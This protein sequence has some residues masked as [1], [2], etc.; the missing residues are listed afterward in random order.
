MAEKYLHTGRY[1]VHYTVSGNGD[2][3]VLVHGFGEDSRIWHDLQ[4]SLEKEYTVVVP[5]LPGSGRST[6]DVAGVTME[7]L[8]ETVKLVLDHENI[9]S[10]SMI[11]HSM[12]GY[13]TMAFAAQYGGM[14]SR[15]GLFSSSAFA[16]SDEKK[17]GRR[18]NMAF[19]AKHGTLKFLEQSV[20][21]L[22]SPETNEKNPASVRYMIDRYSN[23]SPASLVHY[24]EAMMNRPDRTE[25]LKNFPGPALFILGEFDTAVPLEQGLKQSHLPGIS[26]IYVCTHSGHLGMIEETE[27]CINAV[28]YFLA[29]K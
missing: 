17:A 25:V 11:G 26:Y 20:P 21:K 24:T 29:G 13:I 22:F 10:C 1:P 27:F 4:E 28:K 2:P 3:V 7:G 19:I 8:A 9:R 18:K 12:G 15:L 16:D 14:L 6:T 5:D 23:L